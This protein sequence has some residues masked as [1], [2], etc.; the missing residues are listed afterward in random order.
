MNTI[1][2]LIVEDEVLV[3]E[4]ISDYLKEF[5]FNVTGIA[6]S[7][8]ECLSLLDKQTPNVILMDI[9]IKGDLDGIELAQLINKRFSLPIIFLTAN[10][11]TNTTQRA[12][13]ANPH[14]FLS[15]PFNV[16]DLKIAIELAFQKFNQIQIEQIA[17][18]NVLLSKSIF[19][20]KNNSYKKIDIDDVLYIEA[21]GS[22]C[23]LNT[24]NEQ[25]T[26]SHNLNHFENKIKN[27]VFVRIHRSYVINLN[28]VESFDSNSVSFKNKTL[29]IS[30]QYQKE[31]LFYFNKV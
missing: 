3:A 26:L 17:K 15:K 4:D 6:V 21:S 10:N 25:F 24:E 11:D 8:S 28:K 1:N 5:G 12:L 23:I 19:V 22:Y 18:A 9:N 14:S 20:K 13:K 2:I 31:I 27:P 29:P 30:K 7:A 16:T